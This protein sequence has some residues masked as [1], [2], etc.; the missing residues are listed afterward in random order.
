MAEPEIKSAA[1]PQAVL[2]RNA[3]ETILSSAAEAFGSAFVVCLLGGIALSIAGSFAGEMIPSL[4]PGFDRPQAGK[5]DNSW[6]DTAQSGAFGFF[7]AIFFIHSLWVGF[8]SPEIRAGK[9]IERILS[10]L[11]ENWFSLIVGNAIGAWVAVLVLGVVPNFS[12]LHMLWE[13]VL[14][15]VLPVA[16]AIAL[17]VFGASNTASLSDWFSWF[18][19]NQ[20]K[21]YFWILYLAGAFDDLGVPNIKT[22]ARWSWRRWQKRKAA[23]LPEAVDRG[24]VA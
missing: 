16:R 11:R 4:P 12:P 15:M 17:H 10:N 21:L 9:R 2:R 14:G 18:N 19:A 24:E 5:A 3:V 22:L 20:T 7:F 6:W 13:W 1:D 23:P 8:R